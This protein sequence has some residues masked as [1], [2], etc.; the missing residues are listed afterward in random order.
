MLIPL[1]A[2]VGGAIDFTR[3]FIVKSRL[4]NSLDAAVLATAAAASLGNAERIAYGKNIFKANYPASELGTPAEAVITI[5]TDGRVT[6]SVSANLSTTLLNVIGIENITLNTTNEAQS[7]TLSDAEIVLVLDYSG[8]MNWSGKYQAMRDASINLIN[9]LSQNGS[10]D[11]VK[12]GLVPFSKHVY[13]T[14]AS[15][16]IV[17]ETPGGT[18][19]NCTMDRKWPY[20]IQD[21]TPILADNNTK[22]GMACTSGDD[23]DDEDGGSCD[24]YSVCSSYTSRNLIMRPLSN[25]H[26]AIINQIQSMTPYSNTHISLGLEFGWHLIA[27]NSPWQEG[28]AYDTEDVLKAIVLLTDGRQTSKGWGPGNSSSVSNA[29]SNLED[30]CEA[31]KATNVLLVTVAFDLNDS[32]TENRLRNCATSPAYFFDA[33]TN[34]SLAAAFESIAGQISKLTLTK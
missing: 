17:N 25:N 28:V 22:W 20:N 29:E 11:K 26:S 27:P 32:A 15:D 2:M 16:Y 5:S 13:G 31:I 1:M 34:A 30:M 9:T 19:T 21:S 14:I 7:A 12:F 10:N 18:W 8:S 3:A 24:P 4:Q 33:D 23:D 6:G